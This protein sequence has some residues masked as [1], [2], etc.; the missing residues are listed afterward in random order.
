MTD[1]AS[2]YSGVNLRYV[3]AQMVVW[4]LNTKMGWIERHNIIQY[5]PFINRVT[6]ARF[7]QYCCGRLQFTTNYSTEDYSTDQGII[8]GG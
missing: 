1:E 6:E 5:D 4:I 3:I 2:Y 7:Y 8:G